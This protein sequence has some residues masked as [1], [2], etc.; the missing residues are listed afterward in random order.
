MEREKKVKRNI[1]FKINTNT[2]FDSLRLC[3]IFAAT[4][5]FHSS[6]NF[7]A[8]FHGMF[9]NNYELNLIQFFYF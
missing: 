5:T 4:E 7:G 6:S 3:S 2:N 8:S 9:L 1:N